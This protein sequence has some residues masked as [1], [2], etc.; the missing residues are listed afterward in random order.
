MLNLDN[1]RDFP[2]YNENPKMSKIG[3]LVLLICIPVAYYANGFVSVFSNEIIGSISFLLI[4][5]IPLLYFS[6]WDY[7]LF[8]QKPTKNELILAVLMCLASE[9]YKEEDY[10]RDYEEFLE[11]MK[12]KGNGINGNTV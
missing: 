1:N 4:L 8:F 6:N 5:L 11:F 3:W 2:Y 9:V 7:S 12:D 10:I